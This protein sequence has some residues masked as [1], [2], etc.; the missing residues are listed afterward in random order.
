MGDRHGMKRIL[1]AAGVGLL[2]LV[3][4]ALTYGVWFVRRVVVD[5]VQVRATARSSEKGP[6][7]IEV[8]A[9]G[10]QDGVVI[11][12]IDMDRSLRDT[13]GLSP[14]A[15]FTLEPL[16]VEDREKGD[17]R[18]VEYVAKYNREK[19]RYAGRLSVGPN[20]PAL[21]RF[22]AERPN[23]ASGQIRLQHERKIGVGGSIGFVSVRIG[24]QSSAGRGGA[25]E[26]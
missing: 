24:P 22:S 6:I 2:V 23:A 11:T 20:T 25:V 17:N 8:T 21:L 14:P 7:E 4:A 15:G 1:L 5:H 9:A 26:Q 10:S 18:A 19:V 3:G 12:D 13:L 16:A